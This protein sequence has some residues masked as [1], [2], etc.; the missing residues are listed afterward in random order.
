MSR[1]MS[2]GDIGRELCEIR[3]GMGSRAT[4]LEGLR[5]AFELGQ[6]HERSK[7]SQAEP[8]DKPAPSLGHGGTTIQKIEIVVITG[9]PDPSR[10]ARAFK[11][12]LENIDEM[13]GA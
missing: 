4:Q 12:A 11:A 3:E 1:V 2:P 10:I 5:Q 8:G 13:D 6:A 9:E 7:S